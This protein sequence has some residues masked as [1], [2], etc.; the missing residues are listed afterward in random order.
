MSTIQDPQQTGKTTDP[1]VQLERKRKAAKSR[2]GSGVRGIGKTAEG[3]FDDKVSAIGRAAKARSA[4]RMRGAEKGLAADVGRSARMAR[5]GGRGSMLSDVGKGLELEAKA[6]EISAEERAIDTKLQKQQFK[7]DKFVSRADA[8]SNVE[9]FIESNKDTY[10]K[11]FGD[12]ERGMAEALEAYAERDD[13]SENEAEYAL[14]QA[15]AFRKYE[16]TLFGT[17][18]RGL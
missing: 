14:A 10:M 11:A 3:L 9:A 17:Q 2:T 7:A 8:R 15:L 13:I 5:G 18:G 6:D 12:D 1:L 4:A 16:D